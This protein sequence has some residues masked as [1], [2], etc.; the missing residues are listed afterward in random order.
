M[1]EPIVDPYAQV[2]ELNDSLSRDLMVLSRL[3]YAVKQVT[4]E[5][6][7]VMQQAARD[8]GQPAERGAKPTVDG[9]ALSR[10]SQTV[11]WLQRLYKNV[12]AAN[13]LANGWRNK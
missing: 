7:A 11:V 5:T 9:D 2:L 10:A 6:T 12:Q 13:D 8:A 3:E 4:Q 1:A